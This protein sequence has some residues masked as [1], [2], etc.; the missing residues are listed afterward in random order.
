M[1][2]LWFLGEEKNTDSQSFVYTDS[3]KLLG[4]KYM[5]F[6]W[7][8]FWIFTSNFLALWSKNTGGTILIQFYWLRISVQLGA[9]SFLV[10]VPLALGKNVSSNCWAGVQDMLMRL[11]LFIA[12][13]I[14]SLSFNYYFSSASI[15]CWEGH[16]EIFTMTIRW[17]IFPYYFFGTYFQIPVG[18]V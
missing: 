16:V 5:A 17:T 8:Y 9:E 13:F 7:F 4:S 6:F 18:L 1:A 10:K 15:I 14:F 2:F 11:S 3:R 12:L